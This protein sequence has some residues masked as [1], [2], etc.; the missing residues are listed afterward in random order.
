[1]TELNGATTLAPPAMV[2]ELVFNTVKLRS[3]ALPTA[4][5]PKLVAVVGV[6]LKSASATPLAAAEHALSLPELSTA[7]TCATYVAPTVRPVR[8]VLTTSPTAGVGVGD[9]MATNV[10]AGHDAPVPR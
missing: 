10:D 9:G 2:T 6:T 3:T 8:R 1:M 7:V 4:T 5:L